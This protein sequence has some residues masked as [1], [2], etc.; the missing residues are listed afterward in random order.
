MPEVLPASRYTIQKPLISCR[1][2]ALEKHLSQINT[3]IPDTSL[4]HPPYSPLPNV[5]SGV[6]GYRE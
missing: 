6:L 5:S 2:D 1:M 3:Q 4:G